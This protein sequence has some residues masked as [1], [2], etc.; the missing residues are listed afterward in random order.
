VTS[1]RSWLFVDGRSDGRAW[2]QTGAPGLRRWRPAGI[3]FGLS[4]VAVL[5]LS[6]LPAAASGDV[7][8]STTPPVPPT[9]T[10]SFTLN[11]IA[12]GGTSTLT[13]SVGNPDPSTDFSTVAFT[14]TL[15]AGLAVASTPATSST[16]SAGVVTANPGSATV[17]LSGAT[18]AHGATCDIRLRVEA[19]QT[20]DLVDSVSASSAQ[21]GAGPVASATLAVVAAANCVTATTALCLV[22]EPAEQLTQIYQLINSATESIDMTMYELSDT[23]AEQDLIAAHQRGVTVR[24]ILDQSYGG[25]DAN[26]AAFTVLTAAG[27]P[28]HWAPT[29][30]IYH[31]KTLTIDGSVSAIGTANLTAQYYATS[32]DFWIIDRQPAD[33]TAVTNT[34]TYDWALRSTTK[35]IKAVT[36]GQDLIW[37]PGSR[38]ALVG[39]IDQAQHTLQ[40]EN[41]EMR[42]TAIV[43]ALETA[44]R[45]GVDVQ[46]T[47]TAS[48]TWTTA[49][50]QLVQAGVHVHTYAETAPLYI[51][52]KVILADD[53]TPTH[54]KLFVGSENF[55]TGSMEYNRELGLMVAD[56]PIADSIHAVLTADFADGTPWSTTPPVR[57]LAVTATGG[58]ASA[59]VHWVA[60]GAAGE[61]YAVT[62]ANLTT[63]ATLRM[64]PA[65]QATTVQVPDLT[66]GDAYS[67]AVVGTLD[68][69]ASAPVT[70]NVVVVTQVAPSATATG[71]SSASL[72]P[73]GSPGSISVGT[74]GG[75]PSSAVT[76]S[77]Y[78]AD[79]T[80]GAPSAGTFFDVLVQPGST[81]TSVTAVV[82]GSPTGTGV[83]WWNPVTPGYVPVADTT[84]T[85]T[86]GCFS[87]LFTDSTTPSLADLDGTIL[88][89]PNGVPPAPATSGYWEAAGDG[90]IFA[91][92]S[93][94]FYG[95]MGGQHLNAPV[96]GMAAT[97]DDH[98]YWEVA[99]DGGIFAFG[100]AQFY[101]TMGGQHLNAP[102]VGMAATPD[103][104][105]YWEVAGD[106]GVFAFGDAGYYG[107]MAGHVLDA[108]V[109]G[110]AVTPDGKGYWEVAGDGGVF[111][112]G[113]AGYHGS[114]AGH[115]LDAPVVGLAPSGNG[116]YE[117]AADGGVFAFGAATFAGSMGGRTLNAPVVS[118]AALK[119]GAG[120]YEVAA[121]GGVFA[122]GAATFA[123]SMGGRTLTAPMVG[124]GSAG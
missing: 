68:G 36:A 55:S 110:L 118:L 28:V 1:R 21:A 50:N 4:V 76:A 22:T 34:F 119:A 39:I 111:A 85:G 123:G 93:A 40:I 92:G 69:R 101:G 37:S 60:P 103:D 115:V 41:E 42:S 61:S 32:R 97:P 30:V 12:N 54:Q 31:Q 90:G 14:D 120:Y 65:D 19:S 107:S 105:G 57:P 43:T 80:S 108:P 71:P 75:S 6:Q 2:Q 8:S 13:I 109:V 52:A 53:G 66:A 47:M 86:A 77:Q 18:L 98:G 124:V 58:V 16:C 73:P 74:T 17:S 56:Q 26:R 122:F 44:A 9:A 33:V 63:G 116:Y 15:P 72:G 104:H 82:C 51:H 70:S 3:L 27:V 84:P 38:T 20:G 121:D 100:S 78:P 94:Q 45:R 113:D 96:V 25:Y 112:F 46:V 29:T 99:S 62:P 106:G 102:V 64:L 35:T 83:D 49:F 114:M 117:V 10:P 81:Y 88:A 67:F 24:V 59:T 89:V 95:S 5:A 11:S 7:S 48:T 91:F 23:T 79:P 87:V